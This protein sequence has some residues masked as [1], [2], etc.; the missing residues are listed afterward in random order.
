MLAV[1]RSPRNALSP[2][3][4][5][6]CVTKQDSA[7]VRSLN[8]IPDFFSWENQD[9]AG[10]I[11]SDLMSDSV[12]LSP[13]TF[14]A[15]KQKQLYEKG[16]RSIKEAIFAIKAGLDEVLPN[17]A[18]ELFTGEEFEKMVNG[19]THL[20]AETL[21]AGIDVRRLP[22]GSRISEWLKDIIQDQSEEF[23]FAFN[24]FVTGV[25]QPPA[26]RDVPW[27]FVDVESSLSTSSLPVAHTCFRNLQL[28]EYPDR[29]TMEQKL[30]LAIFD[31]NGSLE[32]L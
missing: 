25:P 10:V 8:K 4:L 24:R 3:D 23:R 7:F 20:S 1:I 29:G 9:A 11:L 15:Y 13:A 16:I 22:E 21:W 18:L 14:P 2:A 5:E 27:I 12:P 6:E 28:P 30:L 26:T 32:L 19:V 17:G 31:G